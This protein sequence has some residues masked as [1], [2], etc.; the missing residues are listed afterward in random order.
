[1]SK[2]VQRRIVI[3]GSVYRSKFNIKQGEESRGREVAEG[4]AAVMN[5]EEKRFTH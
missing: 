1:M 2:S 5:D 3:N 4:N